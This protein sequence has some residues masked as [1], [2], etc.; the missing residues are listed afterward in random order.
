MYVKQWWSHSYL[1][2]P[3]KPRP[4]SWTSM[5]EWRTHL[6]RTSNLCTRLMVRMPTH[7]LHT[8]QAWLDHL[9]FIPRLVS[10]LDHPLH[11]SGTEI[12]FPD[13]P[14]HGSGTEITFPDHPLHGWL[15]WKASTCIGWGSYGEWLTT[16]MH[17]ILGYKFKRDLN[18]HQNL[19]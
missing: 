18:Y 16:N 13:H 15:F 4:T 14:L 5:A 2:H 11:E 17:C 10:V 8:S 9:S 19:K 1:W 3:Q 7:G 6:W 12:T